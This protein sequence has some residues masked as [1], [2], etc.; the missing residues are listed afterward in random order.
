M[1]QRSPLMGLRALLVLSALP[2]AASAVAWA[3]DLTAAQARST[4]PTVVEL[5]TSQGCSSCPP[6]DALLGDLARRPDVVALSFHVNYWDRLGW[7]DP[8]ATA[9]G[10]DRQRA[11]AQRMALSTVYTPQMV[12][13]GRT[14]VAGSRPA[15]VMAALEDSRARASGRLPLRLSRRGNALAVTLGEGPKGEGGLRLVLLSLIPRAENGVNRGENAG[16]HLSHVNVVRSLRDLGAWDG[17]AET[18]E[19]S[20]SGAE[21]AQKDRLAVLVQR[22]D[23]SGAPGPILGA[24]ILEE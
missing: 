17:R 4:A 14:D 22:R 5:F 9:W 11:Y 16:R 1:K 19:V 15:Q 10:T 6:A 24:G 3:G 2:F 12:I 21:L 20:L 8:Y 13:D 23:A 7:P 18:R